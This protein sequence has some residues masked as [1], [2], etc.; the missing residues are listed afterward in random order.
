MTSGLDQGADG[1]LWWVAATNPVRRMRVVSVFATFALVLLVVAGCGAPAAPSVILY[2][3]DVF[4]ADPARTRAT[5]IAIR[6]EHIVAVGSNAEIVALAGDETSAAFGRECDAG[7]SSLLD[8]RRRGPREWAAFGRE[9][10]AGK[11]V[12]TRCSTSRPARM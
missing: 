3:A 10:D 5:A 12:S 11:G 9:C 4:T 1:V 7:K 6:G 8:V 2:N